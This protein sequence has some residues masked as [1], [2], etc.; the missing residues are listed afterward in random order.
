MYIRIYASAYAH[1]IHGITEKTVD[2]PYFCTE[3]LS[4]EFLS[5]NSIVVSPVQK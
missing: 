1:T 4:V 3:S 5:E 2:S